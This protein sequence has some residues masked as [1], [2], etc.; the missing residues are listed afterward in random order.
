MKLG[1]RAMVLTCA[2]MAVLP[3]CSGDGDVD[4]S[5]TVTPTVAPTATPVAT[6]T[7]S[8]TMYD[9][10]GQ[11]A[12]ITVV[13]NDFVGR[14]VADTKING[15]FLNSSV[16]GTRLTNCL[17]KFVGNIS[18]GPQVYP[19]PTGTVN[20]CRDMKASHAGMGVSTADYNDLAGHF[21]GALQSASVGQSDIDTLVAALTDPTFVGDIVEDAGNNQTIYQRVGRKPAIESVITDFVGR[22]VGDAKINGYFLNSTVDAERLSLCLVRQ[23]CSLDGPC[24]YGEEVEDA[25]EI[26]GTLVP[27]RDML[28]THA[29]MGISSNDYGDL[30]G[31]LV[32]SLTAAGVTTSD[33]NALVAIFTEPGLVGSIVEDADNNETVYQ[34]VGRKPAV[35]L[36]VDSLITRVLADASISGFFS[37]ADG[38]RLTTCLVRQ[39][40]GIDGPCIYGKDEPEL[41]GSTCR[42]MDSSHDGLT[43]PVGGSGNPITITDF[44]TLVGH[45]I[46]AM[47]EFSVQS[48]DQSAIL[49]A[50]GPLCTDIVADPSTCGS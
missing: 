4:P 50:L 28:S 12:G 14:V 48:S 44:N 7:A 18:G 11:E 34:R 30:A 15:Y 36:V 38:S 32:D 45:L 31:H 22:V 41:D 8:P 1:F 16:D 29:G 20:G 13:I 23:V 25:A 46:D 40:C 10:L 37:N 17:V 47:N 33:V 21:V 35:E 2:M 3:G 27:C 19:D 42:P 24:N 26:D 6:P 5:P 39:V 9:R 43:N 49:G